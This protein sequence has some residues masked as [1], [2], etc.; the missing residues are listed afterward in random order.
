MSGSARYRGRA[1]NRRGDT[2]AEGAAG[3]TDPT[4]PLSSLVPPGMPPVQPEDFMGL[5]EGDDSEPETDHQGDGAEGVRDGRE[6]VTMGKEDSGEQ[7]LRGDRGSTARSEPSQGGEAT[8]RSSV[9]SPAPSIGQPPVVLDRALLQARHAQLQAKVAEKRMQDEIMQMENELAGNM[10]DH[11]VPIA[12]TALPTRKRAI[13]ESAE[14]SAFSRI[15]RA[16]LPRFSG[17]SSRELADYLNKWQVELEEKGG[18]KKGDNHRDAIVV[19]AKGL[20]G[21]ALSKWLTWNRR[22]EIDDWDEYVEF[23]KGCII[24][25][26]NRKA[27]AI[28]EK[29]TAKQKPGQKV[30][31]LLRHIVELEADIPEMDAEQEKGW[32]FLQ[33][34]QEET[35]DFILLY[36]KDEI[37]SREQVVQLAQRYEELEKPHKRGGGGGFARSSQ[38]SRSSGRPRTYGSGGPGTSA[39]HKS[40][41]NTVGAATTSSSTVKAPAQT[42]PIVAQAGVT[43]ADDT[44]MICRK[45]NKKGHRAA[46]CPKKGKQSKN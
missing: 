40:P 3:P 45:C 2:P 23:C 42:P 1:R 9:Y 22:L 43:G 26:A 21:T 10:P 25:P 39:S 36:H 14:Q 29:M 31:Q 46:N 16:D 17:K 28:M 32:Q 7:N 24:D 15:R 37:T 13:T 18:L 27:N 8:P 34:L 12:G 33:M 30:Q 4:G 19:A 20:E 6:F 11:Y 38:S 5:P 44:H 41:V 35:R